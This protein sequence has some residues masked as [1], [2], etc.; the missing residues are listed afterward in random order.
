M[1]RDRSTHAS[2]SSTGFFSFVHCIL[3]GCH[4]FP[5]LRLGCN[6][7]ADSGPWPATGRLTTSKHCVCHK[8]MPLSHGL[9]SCLANLTILQPF[10]FFVPKPGLVVRS[11]AV[12]DG[13]FLFCVDW[14]APW[15]AQR[16]KPLRDQSRGADGRGSRGASRLAM[17]RQHHAQGLLD[18]SRPEPPS[19]GV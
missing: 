17:P 1:N 3:F 11:T 15:S 10:V 16:I 8:E 14:L 2:K 19:H 9:S 12:V 5:T 4:E 7:L 18:T 6:Q 13:A